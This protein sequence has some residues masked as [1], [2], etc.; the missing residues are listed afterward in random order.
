M[1]LL[2]LLAFF[3]PLHAFLSSFGQGRVN[4]NY[5]LDLI[6]EFTPQSNNDE[7]K[8]GQIPALG[9]PVQAIPK[10]FAHLQN[11]FDVRDPN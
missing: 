1:K 5:Y 7:A 11:L 10:F 4:Q 2:L 3:S 6:R 9:L 8:C